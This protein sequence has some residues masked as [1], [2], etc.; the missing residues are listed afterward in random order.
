MI[1]VD[2]IEG[3]QIPGIFA[4]RKYE[5]KLLEN[6]REVKFNRIYYRPLGIINLWRLSLYLLS[7][8]QIFLYPFWTALR[9]KGQ[10]KHLASQES[11]YLLNFFNWP[12]SVVTIY[13]L[14]GFKKPA[15]NNRIYRWYLNFFKR[16]LKKTRFIVTISDYSKKEIGQY[17]NFPEERIKVVYPAIEHY[18]FKPSKSQQETKKGLRRKF[19]IK[20]PYI[21]YVGSEQK[22]KNLPQ[23]IKVFAEI[24]KEFPNLLLVKV[25]NPQQMGARRQLLDLV[26]DLDLTDSVLFFDQV[27]EEDLALFYQ[28]AEVFVFLSEYEGFGMPVLESLAC[29]CPVVCSNFTSLPEVTGNAALLV[30]PHNQ[31]EVAGAVQR[32]LTNKSLKNSLITKGVQQASNFS[33]EKSATRLKEVYLKLESKKNYPLET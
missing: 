30:N 32:I 20:N 29:G 13:D 1:T 24:K 27:S 33:W 21:L 4:R 8:D 6:L 5:E 28:G 3:L 17:L 9:I 11:G 10:I 19:Q 31:V 2:F 26:N 25:G 15:F 23:L 14:I 22:R 18:L 16:G 7:L 12:K